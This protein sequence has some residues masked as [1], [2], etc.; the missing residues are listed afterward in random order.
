MIAGRIG[1]NAIIQTAAALAD[2]VGAVRADAIVWRAVGRHLD[3]MPTA[4]V[5]EAEVIA[6]VHELRETMSPEA[7]AAVLRDAGRRTAEYLLAHRIPRSVRWVLHRMPSALALR[8]LLL[9]VARHSWT[10]AGTAEVRV[11]LRAPITLALARCPMCR[12][13][14]SATPC[15]DFYV[16]TLQHLVR[17]LVAPDATVD[18]VA[19]AAS[20]APACVIRLA[21]PV[22]RR[23][24]FGLSAER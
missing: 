2:R 11:S 17:R 1:P 19:C 24:R 15:C 7:R 12:G 16:G 14:R 18:E 4:L 9:A 21:R 5:D 20:G 6:L 8:L 3:Q 23:R 22:A 13:L 10:F